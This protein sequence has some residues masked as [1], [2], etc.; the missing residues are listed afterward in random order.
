MNIIKLK[1]EEIKYIKCFYGL[2]ENMINTSNNVREFLNKCVSSNIYFITLKINNN[3]MGSDPFPGK[4]KNFNLHFRDTQYNLKEGDNIYFNI[5]LSFNVVFKDEI[6]KIGL[7]KYNYATIFGKGPTFKI[8]DKNED[9]VELRC[10][11][12]QASNIA[13]DVDFLCMNDHHNL[14]KIELDTYKN[15][16]YLLIPEYLHINQKPCDE[17]YFVNI[18]E[19]LDG[20]FYG[21]LIIYNLM[22]SKK[23]TE[24]FID[25]NTAQSSGNNCFEFICINTKIKKV[26]IYGMGKKSKNNYN[27]IFVGNGN[28]KDNVIDRIV[29]VLSNCSQVYKV[30]YLIN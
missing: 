5:K 27:D 13:K 23:K 20:K 3:N 6:N 21:N 29:S 24:Y 8:I 25:L 17:G 10:A 26:N 15:L 2:K 16:K 11:I 4:Q 22:T 9:L 7:N 18:L 30:K 14:F 1:K 19:Y 28:Y 12:N